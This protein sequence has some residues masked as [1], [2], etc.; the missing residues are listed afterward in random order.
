MKKERE[1]RDDVIEG[2]EVSTVT[3]L[4]KEDEWEAELNAYQF[5]QDRVTGQLKASNLVK[6]ELKLQ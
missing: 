2:Q 5:L 3:A 4:D 6:F 1:E